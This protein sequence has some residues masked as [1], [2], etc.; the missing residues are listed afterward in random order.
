MANKRITDRGLLLYYTS[1]DEIEKIDSTELG[2]LIKK[3]MEWMSGRAS[4]PEFEDVRCD[5]F[6]MHLKEQIKVRDIAT[7]NHNNSNE[8]QVSTYTEPKKE[9]PQGTADIEINLD[10]IVNHL[11]E[12]QL[13]KGKFAREREMNDVAKLYSIDFDT[14]FHKYND[15]YNS[16]GV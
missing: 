11:V 15:V 9:I 16:I 12:T 1:L 4:E 13:T 14:L 2:N 10:D 6:H 3:E 8:P 7:D 5:I